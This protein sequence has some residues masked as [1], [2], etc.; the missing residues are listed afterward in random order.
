MVLG[1][2]ACGRVGFDERG[3]TGDAATDAPPDAGDGL[4]AYY[5]MD[6]DPLVIIEASPASLA[7]ACPSPCPARQVVGRVGS[8]AY[9]FEM[10]AG[11]IVLPVD[12]GTAPFT[13]AFWM[14]PDPFGGII[15]PLAQPRDDVSSANLLAI[16]VINGDVR[17]ESAVG[18][19]NSVVPEMDPV[20]VDSLDWVH[21]AAAWDGTQRTLYVNGVVSGAVTGGFDASTQRFAIGG[22][23]D[24]DM[25]ME[26]LIDYI[27][28]LDELRIY[29]RALSPDEVT[30]LASP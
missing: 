7:V 11:R 9:R 26:T 17:W 23:R 27:G 30:A 25:G 28:T 6:V 13:V 4:V 22:D 5:P 1:V 29:N 2:A 15:T 18:G 14:D 19:T 3:L 21:I 20:S 10:D 16:T 24:V 8:G 12:L